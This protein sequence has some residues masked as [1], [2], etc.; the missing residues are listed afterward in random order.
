MTITA[1]PHMIDA[2]APAAALDA[3]SRHTSAPRR[4]VGNFVFYAGVETVFER[5]TDPNQIA[6]WM[7]PISHGSVDHSASENAGDWGAGS[8]RFCHTTNM[9]VLDE[10]I[11]EFRPLSFVVYKI[12]HDKMPIKDHTG[13][14]RF[15]ADGPRR[16]EVEWAQYFNFKP[17][18]M[19]FLFPM[20]MRKMM[21]D[22]MVELRKEL[23]GEPGAAR[24]V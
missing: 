20:M 1:D 3:M 6:G 5:M 7:G 10:S 15:T 11:A 23:G 17:G 14:M 9:G 19:R 16:T 18:L 12:K 24:S 22:G 8:K 21:N 4:I 13:Y 2:L